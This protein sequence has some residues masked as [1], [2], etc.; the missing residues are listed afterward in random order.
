[1]AKAKT[2]EVV[3]VNLIEMDDPRLNPL[4]EDHSMFVSRFSDWVW[5][6]ATRPYGKNAQTHIDKWHAYR[7]KAFNN[8]EHF[9]AAVK[10]D[11]IDWKYPVSDWMMFLKYKDKTDET[12]N[13]IRTDITW[14]Y[15]DHNNQKWY[16]VNMWK[17]PKGNWYLRFANKEYRPQ[18][19]WKL[20][21]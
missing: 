21:F 12:G 3:F 20:P 17:N 9:N 2:Q 14:P 6:V 15:D 1:M 19:D 11:K 18:D 8:E 4:D 7:V 16:R 13:I 10:W 5:Y